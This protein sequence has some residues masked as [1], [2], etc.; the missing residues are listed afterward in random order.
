MGRG[1]DGE[2]G[3]VLVFVCGIAVGG[4]WG[5]GGEYVGRRFCRVA[6]VWVEAVLRGLVL[7]VVV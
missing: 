5:Y 3:A 7:L 2:A 6:G 1:R 4:R